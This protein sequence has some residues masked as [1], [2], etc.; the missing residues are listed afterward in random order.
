GLIEMD[1]V[2]L[3]QQQKL[4]VVL[5]VHQNAG[6]IEI[7]GQVGAVVDHLEVVAG[8]RIRYVQVA[9][10]RRRF[11]QRACQVVFGT[12]GVAQIDVQPE[13][14]RVDLFNQRQRL[15]GGLYIHARLGFDQQGDVFI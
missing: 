10:V 12:V 11:F 7:N 13:A 5:E 1:G 6:R 3:I 8:L 4:R 14:R 9:G 15:V 2:V